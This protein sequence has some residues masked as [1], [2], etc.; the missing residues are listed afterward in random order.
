[1]GMDWLGQ[2][3]STNAGFSESYDFEVQP[4]EFTR[5]RTGGPSN[6]WS[7]DGILLQSGRMFRSSGKTW[8]PVTFKQ[9]P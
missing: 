3:G 7:V 5:L 9:K 6:D 8:M 1:M 2:G 4:S